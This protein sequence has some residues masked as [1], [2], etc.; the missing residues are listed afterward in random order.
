LRTGQGLVPILADRPTQKDEKA[1][2][3]TEL[4][5]L[6]KSNSDHEAR[7]DQASLGD[8]LADLRAVAD[9]LELDFAGANRVA[10][11]RCDFSDKWPFYPRI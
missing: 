1:M 4:R 3:T 8:L 6:L 10:E 5:Y 2:M 11:A 7:S 9:D